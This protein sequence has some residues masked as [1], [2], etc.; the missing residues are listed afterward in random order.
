[1]PGRLARRAFLGAAAVAA[2]GACTTTR[3]VG[4]SS[5]GPTSPLAS[6]DPSVTTGMTLAEVVR[7]R[8][9]VRVFTAEP[10]DDDA[11]ASLL[12]AAQG[13]T[14][15][16]GGRTAPS[17]GGLYPLEVYAAMHTGL[18]R[19]VP[20]AHAVEV[21]S[22]DRRP[23]IAAATGGQDAAVL[24]PVL[25]V[26]SGVVSRTAAKYGDRAERYV[27]LEA[28][29]ACQNLLLEATALGLGAVPIGAFDDDDLR[30]ALGVG[31]QEQPLYVIPCGHPGG[32]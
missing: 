3:S 30:A 22:G 21:A 15:A 1:M 23:A 20:G 18:E 27:Q 19:Y 12:F 31:S 9:S 24:A 6:P 14:A 2:A 28:G 17:A 29:H 10:V 16:W 4:G 32:E 8:R 13:E 7:A 5:L 26:I 11:V 25:F